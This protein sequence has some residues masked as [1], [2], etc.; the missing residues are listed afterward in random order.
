MVGVLGKVRKMLE[1]RFA[2][3]PPQSFTA[4]GTILGQ[5]TLADT[6]MFKV[7][8]QVV[9]AGSTLPNLTLEVKEIP[10]ATILYVGPIPDGKP[11]V[12]TSIT[13]RT[14]VS[15]YTVALSAN[16]YANEQKRPA[17]DFSEIWRAVYDEEPTVALRTS[18]VDELGN[19]YSASN[20]LPVDATITVPP[21]EVAID[22]FTKMPPDN[23]IAVG[24]SDG[25]LT[26]TKRAI[27]IDPDG[28]LDTINMGALVP[29]EFDDIAI[30]NSVIAGQTVATLIQYKVGG[31]GGT[32]VA[33]LT[34][35]YDGSANLIN[36]ART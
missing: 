8:Q 23:L 4:N 14:D 25:T 1:K 35:S 17:I 15:A 36:V 18:L 33:T 22:A 27:K 30:T 31:A 10:S 28:N 24:T 26:G 11:G 20:P 3:V 13:A 16:M 5:V 29:F 21:V 9:L 34:L 12:N 7:K 6:T 2:A 32:V 19:R